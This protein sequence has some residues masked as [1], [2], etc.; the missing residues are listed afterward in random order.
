MTTRHWAISSIAAIALGA[1]G[2]LGCSAPKGVAPAGPAPASAPIFPTTT[3]PPKVTV[4]KLTRSQEQAVGTARDY[5]DTAP[6]SRKGLID[7]LVFEGYSTADATY[8][9]DHIAANW[10]EQA[11]RTAEAYLGITHFSRSG[12]IGQLEFEGYTH[13]QAV[14]GVTRAGL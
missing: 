2:L 5:L 7:Q 14:Y 1:S 11:A 10:L 13:R 3:A 12:L 4:P 9:A 8:G 6:L